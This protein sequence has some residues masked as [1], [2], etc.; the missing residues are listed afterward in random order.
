MVNLPKGTA[1]LKHIEAGDTFL[2]TR[3]LAAVAAICVLIALNAEATQY[4]G[5]APTELGINGIRLH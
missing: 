5:R 4:C 1:K 3:A 2:S